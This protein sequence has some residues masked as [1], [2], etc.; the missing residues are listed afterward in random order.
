MSVQ[1]EGGGLFSTSMLGWPS[2]IIGFTVY[3]LFALQK[4]TDIS[5]T[6]KKLTNNRTNMF[7]EEGFTIPV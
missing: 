1:L 2:I 6:I 3:Q 5:K 4:Q 7:D